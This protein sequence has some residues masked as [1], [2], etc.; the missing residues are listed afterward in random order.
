V[1]NV[2][3]NPAGI[4]ELLNL[5]LQ[6]EFPRQLGTT[7][8]PQVVL[9]QFYLQG[10]GTRLDSSAGNW[11]VVG[12]ALTARVPAGEMWMVH[13]AG[14]RAVNNDPNANFSA[15]I[16]I[17]DPANNAAALIQGSVVNVITGQFYEAGIC[18]PDGLLL[19]SGWGINTICNT[20][21]GI[22]VGGFDVVLNVF[23]HRLTLT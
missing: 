13:T 17:V 11:V 8:L 4:L 1:S 3:R 9:N 18:Y 2:N 20:L 21:G 5:N 19:D 12:T 7:I 6:G 16:R 22:P 14:M 23:Y 15:G 10:C